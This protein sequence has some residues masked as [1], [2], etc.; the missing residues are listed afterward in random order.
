MFG[1]FDSGSNRK[2]DEAIMIAGSAL[3]K[4]IKAASDSVNQS[5][6][7]AIFSRM[8]D[9]FTAG[10]LFGYVQASFTDFELPEKQMDDCMR[11]IFDGIFP[12]GAV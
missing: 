3:H 12:G 8:D 4:Q 11:K 2:V 7:K 1:L 6:R 10:Y 5:N 9:A